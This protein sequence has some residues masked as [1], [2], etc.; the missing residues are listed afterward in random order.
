MDSRR[1]T[2]KLSLTESECQGVLESVKDAVE[3]AGHDR[4][5]SLDLFE[6]LV[7]AMAAAGVDTDGIA[8]RMTGTA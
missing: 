3:Y 6:R 4:D 7:A 2:V 1:Y 5:K 8:R